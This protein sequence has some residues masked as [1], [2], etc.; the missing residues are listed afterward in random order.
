MRTELCNILIN[1]LIDT[2]AMIP[3][4]DFD[5]A[6]SKLRF[7]NHTVD[8][9]HVNGDGW[10]RHEGVFLSEPEITYCLKNFAEWEARDPLA[11]EN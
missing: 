1:T 6:D 5:W 9:P 7:G 10:T 3:E 8:V 11:G 4:A 2:A